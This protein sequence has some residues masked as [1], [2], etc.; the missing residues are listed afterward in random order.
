M[1]NTT[2]KCPNCGNW[3]EGKENIHKFKKGGQDIVDVSENIGEKVGG[4]FGETG[5]KWG[6]KFGRITGNIGKLTGLNQF[7]ETV[8]VINFYLNVINVFMNGAQIELM[9]K[10]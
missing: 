2:Q 9:K 7:K 4:I 5:K 3:C 6:G 10:W 1:A 8:L